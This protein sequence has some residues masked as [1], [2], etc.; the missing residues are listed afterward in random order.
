MHDLTEAR[1][2]ALSSLCRLMEVDP[3][4]SLREWAQ[5]ADRGLT[6]IVE[7]C[8]RLVEEGY[9]ESAPNRRARCIRLTKKGRRFAKSLR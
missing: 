3:A 9:I 6:T 5:E 8:A 2:H 4:P 1:A 7:H